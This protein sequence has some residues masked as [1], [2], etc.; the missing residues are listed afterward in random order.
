MLAELCP[1][2]EEHHTG[3]AIAS[4]VRV[5]HRDVLPL[6][7][8]AGTWNGFHGLSALD[9]EEQAARTVHAEVAAK[10]LG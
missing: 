4:V 1:A 2:H 9:F 3:F 5:A 10:L 6:S 8:L 7:K